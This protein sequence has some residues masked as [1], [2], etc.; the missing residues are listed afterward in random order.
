MNR[1]GLRTPATTAVLAACGLAVGIALS[2]CSAGQIA[3]TAVQEPAINGSSAIGNNITLRNLHLRVDQTSDY[4]QPGS[5]VEL[6]FAAANTSAEDPDKLQSIISD[7]GSVT[8]SGDGTVPPNGVLLVGAPDGQIA[9]LE[10]VEDASVVKAELALT[11]PISN[12][13]TYPFTFNFEKAGAIEADVPISAGETPRRDDGG[14]GEE[15]SD[16]GA[17]H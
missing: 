2:G 7:I 1:F 5:K 9:Q 8:I 15:H 16:T 3:Q 4:V 13:L 11:K 6:L 17:G 10:A 14:S 12:G